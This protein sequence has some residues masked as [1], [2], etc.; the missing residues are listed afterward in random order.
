[1][2]GVRGTYEAMAAKAAALSTGEHAA[3]TEANKGRASFFKQTDALVRKNLT[4]QLRNWGTNLA[5]ILTP[6]LFL[7]MLVLLQFVVNRQLDTP[8]NKCGCECLRCCAYEQ[9]ADAATNTL[10]WQRVCFDS[11]DDPD[12][13]LCSPYDACE[14]YNETNCGLQYST[15]DQSIFC[16][17]ERPLAWPSL[18]QLPDDAYRPPNPPPAVGTTSS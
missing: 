8:S 12:G 3:G 5:L 4:F 17:I 7:G 15:S 6:I 9:V 18:M 2:G 14:K 13:R 10:S 11:S 1:M 16:P